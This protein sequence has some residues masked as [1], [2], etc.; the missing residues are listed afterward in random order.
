MVALEGEVAT[1]PWLAA[2][3]AGRSWITNG[4]LLDFS[5]DGAAPGARLSR[6]SGDTV[7]V[8]ATAA[9]RNDFLG[10]E[11]VMNGRV[12]GS[13]A[14]EATDGGFAATAAVEVTVDGSAW[15]AARITPFRGSYDRPEVPGAN[16]NEYG[17]PLFAHTSPVYI[18]VD[19]APVFMPEAAESL[20]AELRSSMVTIRHKGEYTNDAEREKVLSIYR[21]A[22]AVL[23]AKLG[24]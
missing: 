10:V 12:V 22:M 8:R 21:E 14:S 20:I 24:G 23:K 9:G 5:V 15:I 17:K 2:L 18:D 13:A 4:T 11:I 1:A 16:F 6:V 7:K 19:S 3:R